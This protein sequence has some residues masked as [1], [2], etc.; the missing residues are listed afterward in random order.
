M[1]N[2]KERWEIDKNWQLIFPVIGLLALLY[3]GMKLASIFSFSYL[4]FTIG[5]GLLIAFVLLKLTLKIL[6]ILES[7][8]KVDQKWELIRIFIVF[9]LTG[10]SSM[11]VGRPIISL[12]GITK[13]NLNI[14]L[15]Y[16]LFIFVSLVFYQIILVFLGWAFGQFQFFW[17]FEKKMLRRFGLKI[18][19]IDDK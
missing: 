13:E 16:I 1:K 15:Y 6:K 5:I 11:L 14:I 7:R 10:S 3:I 19:W 2:F 17:E 8:W 12:I 18:W 4:I 9:A